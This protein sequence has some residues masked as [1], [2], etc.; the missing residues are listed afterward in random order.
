MFR[1]RDPTLC[2]VYA[3][4]SY[5]FYYFHVYGCP[6]PAFAPDF[7]APDAGKYGFREWFQV[8]LFFGHDRTKQMGYASTCQGTRDVI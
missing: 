7:D 5:F 3:V 4:A 8:Y 6:R 2:S 1:H